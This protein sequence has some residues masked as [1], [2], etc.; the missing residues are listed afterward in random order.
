MRLQSKQ[1]Q[2][3]CE[4]GTTARGSG[5]SLGGKGS[6]T[7]SCGAAA[8]PEVACWVSTEANCCTRLA[9]FQYLMTENT[10]KVY[11]NIPYSACGGSDL[12][13]KRPFKTL[14]MA[15]SVLYLTL[16]PDIISQFHFLFPVWTSESKHFRKPF[17]F[18]SG[19]IKVF[20]NGWRRNTQ[21]LEEFL[22]ANTMQLHIII[23]V[24]LFCM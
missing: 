20:V 9:C 5:E 19:R 7:S 17:F 4:K 16:S 6:G 21:S 8:G 2:T 10:R 15:V 23:Y 13:G 1:D 11:V 24:H 22:S 3:V 12:G 14:T 18:L